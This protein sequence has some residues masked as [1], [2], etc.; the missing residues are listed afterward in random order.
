MATRNKRRLATAA[1]LPTAIMPGVAQDT[2][3]VAAPRNIRSRGSTVGVTSGAL[4][5]FTGATLMGHVN[6]LKG[7]GLN[8][9]Q[10]APVLDRFKTG[11]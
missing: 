1:V 3:R 9:A 5:N 6:Y 7:I 10:I 8:D 11:W 4:K 2:K